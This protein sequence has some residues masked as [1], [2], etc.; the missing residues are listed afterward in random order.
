[1]RGRRQASK[2][3]RLVVAGFLAVLGFITYLHATS[4]ASAACSALDYIKLYRSGGKLV[5]VAPSLFLEARA[6][7]VTATGY[8]VIELPLDSKTVELRPCMLWCIVK[9]GC[10]RTL[11]IEDLEAASKP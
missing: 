3:Y 1:L 9:L 4:Y 5:I 11:S 6:G 8:E 10:K 7:N 2:S